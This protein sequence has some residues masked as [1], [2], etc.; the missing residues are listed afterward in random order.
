MPEPKRILLVESDLAALNYLSNM[1]RAA[2][3]TVLTAPSG[4]E[5]LIE[6]WRNRPEMLIIVPELPDLNGLE[7]TRKL[8]ADPRTSQAKILL[9]SARNFPQDILTAVQAGADEYIVKRPGAD[10]ELLERVKTLLPLESGAGP[11]S[12]GTTDVL[13]SKAGGKL[14]VFLSAKGGTGTSTLCV[15]IAHSLAV[16]AAGKRVAVVDLV[17]PIGSLADIVGVETPGKN[18][19]EATKLEPR[20]FNA[21]RLGAMLTFRDIWG[22]DLLPGAPDP[23]AAA[24]LRVDRLEAVIHELRRMDD[25]VFVDLGRSLS[26]VSMPLIRMATRVVLVTSPDHAT[27]T[28]TK[29]VLLHFDLHDVRRHRIFPVLNRAVGVEGLSRPDLERELGM[30]M[31][32][33]VPN[34]GGSF[35]FTN[36]QNLPLE[37]R[38]PEDTVTYTLQDIAGNLLMQLN[39]ISEEPAGATAPLS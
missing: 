18:V 6:A 11:S 2:G 7:V 30:N 31:V 24:N 29:T 22:F 38:F 15:N 28:L 23:E 9:L 25:F 36:N 8:R 37:A 39:Q 26:R 3:Y 12:P 21:E 1:L 5:G 13:R 34:M 4:K 19:V 32:A 16:K 35:S 14:V 20:L 10:A 17:L 33:L 27:V